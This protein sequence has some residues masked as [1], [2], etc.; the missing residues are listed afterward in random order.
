MS[1]TSPPKPT[2]VLG[3]KV[4]R[5]LTS[6]KRDRDPYD[7]GVRVLAN[8]SIF[9]VVDLYTEIICCHDDSAIEFNTQY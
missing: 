4:R 3:G 7:A 6:V 1:E 2:I 5:R 8:Q 9:T